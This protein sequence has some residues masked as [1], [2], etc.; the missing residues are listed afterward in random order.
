MDEGFNTFI[1]YYSWERWF[2][3]QKGRRGDAS[4]YGRRPAPIPIDTMP[5]RMPRGFNGML[6]YSKTGAGLVLLREHLMGPERFDFA[7]RT[8][9]ERWSFKAPR[10]ADF[11]RTMEDAAG[12]DLAWFW[13]GWFLEAAELDQGIRNVSWTREDDGSQRVTLRLENLD[14][15]VMPVTVRVRYEDGTD[16]TRTWPVEVWYSSDQITRSW[17]AESPPISI[18]VD[19]ENVLPD[20]DRL[21]NRWSR[22][23]PH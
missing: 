12:M 4:V 22:R 15:M 23:F 17:S 8:Y 5:D 1:N 3:G 21:N 14:A 2:P 16:E 18:V 7:F 9:I 20:S 13:R 6:S 10:P 11:F 19:P